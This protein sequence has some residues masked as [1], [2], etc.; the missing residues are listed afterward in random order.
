MNSTKNLVYPNINWFE[1]NDVLA[2]ARPISVLLL[3]ANDVHEGT[4]NWNT[5]YNNND[6]DD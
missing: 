6:S 4:T 1:L 3:T 2:Y 5:R